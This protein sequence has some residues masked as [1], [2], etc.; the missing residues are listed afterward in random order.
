MHKNHLHTKFSH[1]R[2]RHNIPLN[3]ACIL[4]TISDSVVTLKKLS[5]KL[6]ESLSAIFGSPQLC[7]LSHI[8]FFSFESRFL[9]YLIIRSGFLF[10]IPSFLRPQIGKRLFLCVLKKHGRWSS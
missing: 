7:E 6:L 2:R 9:T 1:I 5:T 10:H 4:K 3:Y 8:S